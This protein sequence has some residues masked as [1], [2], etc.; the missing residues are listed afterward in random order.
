MNSLTINNGT[1]IGQVWTQNPSAKDNLASLLIV[2]GSF[3][4]SGRDGSSVFIGNT[5]L[6][7]NY[8]SEDFSVSIQGGDYETKVGAGDAAEISGVVSGG[9]FGVAPAADLIADD[10]IAA[11]ISGENG[12]VAY[13]VGKE[14]I[15]KAAAKH[16]AEEGGTIVKVTQA[17]NTNNSL[18]LPGGTTV[19][20]ATHNYGNDVDLSINGQNLP[21]II[22]GATTTDP[23]ELIVPKPSPT[24]APVQNGKN[25]WV[26]YNGGNNFSTN[27]KDVPTSVEIDGMPVPF[28]GDGKNFTVS[29]ILSGAE[30]I[31]VRWN[32]TSVTTNFE[33]DANA[34]C[35]S[36]DIPKT[37]DVSIIGYA[38]MAIVAVA[39]AMKIKK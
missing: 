34:F 25:Y 39:G 20:N 22:P 30:R 37:G 33:P 36:V 1:M 21:G 31:T 10:A 9:T 14:A 5:P 27:K 32:S 16:A 23:P 13:A 12:F 19:K 3:E 7:G 28:V 18:E 17:S 15:E 6:G 29:C 26:K 2:D 35:G 38:V 24:Q 8:A 11:E 4:P